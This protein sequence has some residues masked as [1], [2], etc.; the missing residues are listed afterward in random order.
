MSAICQ[1]F[2]VETQN[3]ASPNVVDKRLHCFIPYTELT[4]NI[5]SDK[6]KTDTT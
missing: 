4:L 5:Y 1:S 3:F 6:N 2:H